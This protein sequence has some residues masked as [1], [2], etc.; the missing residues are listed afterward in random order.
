[1]EVIL[2]GFCWVFVL[3]RYLGCVDMSFMKFISYVVFGVCGYV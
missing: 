1:M 2:E 3:R